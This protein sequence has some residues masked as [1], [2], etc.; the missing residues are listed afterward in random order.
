MKKRGDVVFYSAILR[1]AKNITYAH[2]V[3]Y[4]KKF[5]TFF[6]FFL[7]EYDSSFVKYVYLPILHS[8]LQPRHTIVNILLCYKYNETNIFSN[9]L[10][11]FDI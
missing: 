2:I 3:I 9:D 5:E 7:S 4:V 10:S 11:F 6:M 8:F 1:N